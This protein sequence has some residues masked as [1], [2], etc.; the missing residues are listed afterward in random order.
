MVCIYDTSF[1]TGIG[2]QLIPQPGSVKDVIAKYQGHI[3]RSDKVGA[4]YKSLGAI[5]ASFIAS[6]M[7]I[8]S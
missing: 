4:N 6:A 7:A 2:G 1:R 8:G 3:V 5:T